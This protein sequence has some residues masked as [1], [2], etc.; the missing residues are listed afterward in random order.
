MAKHTAYIVPGTWEIGPG[1]Y[2]STPIGMLKGVSDRLDRD[3]WAVQHVNYPARFGPIAQ[4]GEPPLSQL[5][6]PSYEDSVNMGVDEVIRLINLKPGTFAV[7]GYSQGGAV[8]ARIGRE[9]LSGRLQHRKNDCLWLHTFAS[10]HRAQGS[11]VETNLPYIGITGEQI[12]GFRRNGVPERMD[13]FD[14]GL[15]QDVYVNANPRSYLQVGYELVKDMSLV[16]P[17]G[18]G[19]SVLTAATS[20]AI[21]QA[22]N[23]L[24]TNPALFAEKV[25]NTGVAVSQFGDSHTR[26]GIDRVFAGKTAVE[27]SAF[28]LNWWGSR[29]S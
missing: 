10:P 3:I 6:S 23:D 21:A 29:R 2:P 22:A 17:V 11:S 24:V 25:Y 19:G 14:Y 16:D 5:G 9:L 26:Y 20:G 12:G 4:N 27:H 18:W 8:A 13:W 7:L 15:P 1:H 28:H